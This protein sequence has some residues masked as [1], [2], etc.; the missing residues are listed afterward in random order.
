MS[1][2]T[3]VTKVGGAGAPAATPKAELTPE[4]KKARREARKSKR[5]A[6]DLKTAVG[7]DGKSIPLDDKGRLTGVPT[8]WTSAMQPLKRKSFAH[9]K[10][11]FAF[12]ASLIDA[13][14]VELQERKKE[15]LEKAAGREGGSSKKRIK[16]ALKL[17]DQLK[18]LQ[19]QLRAEG[20]DPDTLTAEDGEG[21]DAA[22]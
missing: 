17:K 2:S 9:K 7:A 13:Q 12:R 1:K 5:P 21:E 19:E 22:E 11:F 20:I 6:F 18:A 10:D 4:Q 8:N 14:I 3:K 15:L 16:K